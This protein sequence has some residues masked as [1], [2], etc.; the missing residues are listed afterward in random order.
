MHPAETASPNANSGSA[1]TV[2]PPTYRDR[3]DVWPGQGQWV[4]VAQHAFDNI[5]YCEYLYDEL[6]G[7]VM[8]ASDAGGV[9]P[10]PS[11]GHA[12]ALHLAQTILKVTMIGRHF[13]RHFTIRFPAI[14]F[15]L[16][17]VLQMVLGTILPTQIAISPLLKL[18]TRFTP[19]LS[20]KPTDMLLEW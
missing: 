20:A 2:A 8:G 3:G 14:L 13:D 1:A 12:Y 16:A 7:F 5:Q 6:D 11:D 19:Y 15:I 9:V 17:M 4:I 10:S 18:A